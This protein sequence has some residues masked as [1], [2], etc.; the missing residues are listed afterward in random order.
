MEALKQPCWTAELTTY[1][2]FGW[3]YVSQSI[4]RYLFTARPEYLLRQ[5]LSLSASHT[6]M[7]GVSSA[8]LGENL[9]WAGGVGQWFISGRMVEGLV[10]VLVL[11]AGS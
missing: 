10:E 7:V 5:S 2:L 4:I 3:C 9:Q 6:D 8:G 11:C 1:Y